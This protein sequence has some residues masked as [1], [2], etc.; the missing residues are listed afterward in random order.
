MPAS[1]ASLALEGTG[2]LR[3]HGAFANRST[4]PQARPTDGR[5]WDAFMGG[6]TWKRTVELSW[7]ASQQFEP[8]A[9]DDP[10]S[11]QIWRPGS[12]PTANIQLLNRYLRIVSQN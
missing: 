11:L 12:P 5:R 2:V 8:R 4:H 1:D 9:R 7:I 10:N 6:G 3:P